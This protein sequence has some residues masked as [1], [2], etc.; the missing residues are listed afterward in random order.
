[1]SYNPK[2]T[3]MSAQVTMLSKTLNYNRYRNQD[4]PWKNKF[5]QCLSTNPAFQRIINGK[6]QYKEGND[7]LEKARK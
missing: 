3:Q 6:L 1:M 4:I 7:T 5:T 2:R